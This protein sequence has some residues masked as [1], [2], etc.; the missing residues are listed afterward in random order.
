MLFAAA[1]FHRFV[2]LFALFNYLEFEATAFTNVDLA[3]LQIV[4]AYHSLTFHPN[5]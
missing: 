2:T 4:A 3:Q 1:I 5:R